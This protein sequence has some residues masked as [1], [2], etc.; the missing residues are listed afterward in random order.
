MKINF[1]LLSLLNYVILGSGV[2]EN[3]ISLFTYTDAGELGQITYASIP[4]SRD[5]PSIGFIDTNTDIG[6]FICCSKTKLNS[7]CKEIEPRIQYNDELRY[8]ISSVGYQPDCKYIRT[9][10]N[11]HCQNHKF[12]YG[13][14]PS[15]DSVTSHMATWIT[16]GLYTNDEDRVARP[17]A[18]SLLL[19]TYDAYLKRPRIAVV[20]NTGFVGDYNAFI[21]GSLSPARKKLIHS[22]LSMSSSDSRSII[23]DKEEI[24]I[25][26][27]V[28]IL[29][30]L[31]D[32]DPSRGVVRCEICLMHRDE[33]T[34]SAYEGT[35]VDKDEEVK[36]LV[37]KFLQRASTS[38]S[39]SYP[40]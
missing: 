22:S 40:S 17:L 35:L 30:I 38:A 37:S 18:A 11:S 29:D 33:V 19:L 13:E 6:C 26:K 39:L 27:I 14:N 8:I 7:L 10:L 24:L 31:E 4:V 5:A 1:L 21:V 15:M 9:E 32:E 20:D 12:L 36:Q 3:D 34:M 28:D 25:Q 23:R 16:R 2:S